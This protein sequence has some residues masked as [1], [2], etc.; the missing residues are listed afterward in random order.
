MVSRI[1]S[2][3]VLV[4]L[5]VAWQTRWDYAGSKTLNDG[6]IKWKTDRWTGYA[7]MEV[8][9][10]GYGGPNCIERPASNNKPYY[11]AAWQQRNTATNI[12]RALVAASCI[13]IAFVW[14]V[15]PI[16][17]PAIKRRRELKRTKKQVAVASSNT[18]LKCF[19]CGKLGVSYYDRYLEEYYCSEECQKARSHQLRKEAEPEP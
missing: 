17:L 7:W 8:Y 3:I 2:V 12:W 14:L 18:P 11:D 1:M 5:L 15:S 6:I 10:T 13:W 9:Q 16:V 19:V 4:L